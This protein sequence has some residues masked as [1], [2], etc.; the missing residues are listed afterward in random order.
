MTALTPVGQV[1]TG[2]GMLDSAIADLQVLSGP[3]GVAL[4]SVTGWWGGVTGYRLIGGDLTLSDQVILAPDGYGSHGVGL[5]LFDDSTAPAL[6]VGGINGDDPIRL[7]ASQSGELGAVQSVALTLGGLPVTGGQTAEAMIFAD[8]LS[9]GFTVAEYDGSG[10]FQGSQFIGDSDQSYAVGVIALA[11]LLPGA[12]EI[13][14]TAAQGGF[15]TGTAA[16]QE[17]GITSYR[18]EASG[19]V[20]VDTVGTPEGLGIMTPTALTLV[21]VGGES[22][23]IVGSAQGDSGAIS[24]LKVGLTGLL[25]PVDHLLD[26]RDT[27]FGSVTAL[28]A[29]ALDGRSYVVAGGTDGGLSLFTLLPGGRLLHRTTFVD[30]T[31]LGLEDISRIKLAT[32]DGDL[33]IFVTSQSQGGIAH[34]TYAPGATGLVIEA[35]ATVQS[36]SGTASEDILQGGSGNDV[37]TGQ[38]GNDVLIDGAGSDT[39]DG[40]TGSDIFVLYGDGDTD[41]IIGFEAG[42]DRIDLSDW[43]FMYDPAGLDITIVGIRTRIIHRDEVLFVSGD[44]GAI[45]VE[46]LRASVVPSP[47][48]IFYAPDMVL[49]G[50]S[51]DDI[52]TGSWGQD[53]ISGLDGDDTLTGGAG[54]DL[55]DGG[56][57][58]DTA[59]IPVPLASISG[60][61]L[62]SGAIRVVS[63]R[64]VDIYTSV[65]IFAFADAT[66]TA[67]QLIEIL[68]GTIVLNGTDG[69]DTLTG[70]DGDDRLDGRGGNDVLRGNA[71]NDRL[72][73]G[74]GDDAVDGGS[75]TDTAILNVSQFEVD[76][77][78]LAD[79]F[80]RLISPVGDDVFSAIEWFEFSDGTL[81]REE[82]IELLRGPILGLDLT[83]TPGDDLLTGDGG[84]DVLTGLAGADR[85][86][87]LD[88]D[89]RLSGGPGDDTL[90]G[91][92]GMDVA[93]INS[94]LAATVVHSLAD[95]GLQIDGPGG[96]DRFFDIETFEFTDTTVALSDLIGAQRGTGLTLLGSRA[97][98]IHV[99]SGQPDIFIDPA[100]DDLILTGGGTDRVLLGSGQNSVRP[101]LGDDGLG[102]WISGGY[103]P[104]I[105]EGS[106]GG[107]IIAGDGVSVLLGGEDRITGGLG[108]DILSGGPGRDRFIFETGH[109]NDIIATYG[110][111]AQSPD[112]SFDAQGLSR[113]FEPGLDRIV[114]S[115]I[116]GITTPA[117][118]LARLSNG[119]DGALFDGGPGLTI[120]LHGLTADQ[121]SISDFEIV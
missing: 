60:E 111:V 13:I 18:I 38:A 31:A 1:V 77:Y 48:R 86:N 84:P 61:E 11:S 105:I 47:T 107:D 74:S 10:G 7:G 45:A 104:D 72:T 96:R 43:P 57:G 29:A 26:T 101:G 22:F 30:T 41:E 8:P 58:I 109:G 46:V 120:T 33:H 55:V 50:T 14:I 118:A 53:Q 59:N 99:G 95:G 21:W 17:A 34:L 98:E 19:P 100:G 27:R 117:E 97:D 80:V 20:V 79:G 93:V 103:G 40:G 52:L 73:G 92:A 102:N 23:A 112:G 71:G 15:G 42:I 115:G 3:G 56:A 63:G 119:P 69:A 85:L 66:V 110:R 121:L 12:S 67:A 25:S 116:A 9:S 91:G 49:E 51:G 5:T 54:D 65:E 87:G 6:F 44:G 81:S 24:V 83:G 64:G 2:I 28:D 82:V 89:D 106:D 90:D 68:D 32:Q 108:D 114:M 62:P 16:Q 76:S 113:D 75:G 70:A 94:S 37:I 88:G 36:L 39:L 78:V 35:A 4:Y